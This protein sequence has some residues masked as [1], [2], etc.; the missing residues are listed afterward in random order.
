MVFFSAAVLILL[1][2]S[3]FVARYRKRWFLINSLRINPYKLVFKVTKFAY[4][5]K[6]PLRRS[7][8]T[9]CEDDIPSGLDLGKEKYGG[10]FTTEQVEDVK[11]FYGILKVL[12]ALG[13]VYYLNLAIFGGQFS[14]TILSNGDGT[15]LEYLLYYNTLSSLLT[16]LCIPLYL[17]VVCPV[18]SQYIPGMLKRMGAGMAVAL[19]ALLYTFLSSVITQATSPDTLMCNFTHVESVSNSSLILLVFEGTSYQVIISILVS[20]TFMLI[21]IAQYEFICSQS[22]HFMKGFL[23]GLSVSLSGVF[24]LVATIVTYLFSLVHLSFP[25]CGFIYYLTNIVLGLIG[26]LVYTCVAKKYKYRKR[27]DICHVYRYVDEYYS[28]EIQQ[29]HSNRE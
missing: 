4:Q 8:F 28:K 9:Y 21:S 7:A 23:I 20:L 29:R 17:C 26:L 27:D 5:H 11:A 16:V 19:L 18:V 13:P 6:T 12:F 2:V 14:P 3:L 22:P 24:I 10:P 15:I 25:D 1:L